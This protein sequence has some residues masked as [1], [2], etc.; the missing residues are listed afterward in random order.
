MIIMGFKES[1]SCQRMLVLVVTFGTFLFSNGVHAAKWEREIVVA[2]SLI[3]TDNV[4][5]TKDDKRSDWTGVALLTP[6]GTVSVETSKTKAR[7]SGSV[8]INTLSD[9]DLR[10]DGCTGDSL[11]DRQKYFPRLLGTMNTIL[12]EDWVKLNVSARADQNRIS[13]ARASSNDGL[14]RNGNT[15]T[16]LSV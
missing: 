4:C 7:L 11:D 14:D 8:T 6:S 16:V 1:R 15:N 9:G 10:D 13:S 12:I 2:P 3:Y 5:L